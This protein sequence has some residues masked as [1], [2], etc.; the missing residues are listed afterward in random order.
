MARKTVF[1]KPGIG[2]AVVAIAWVARYFGGWQGPNCDR[3]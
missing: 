1:L 3:P 2:A